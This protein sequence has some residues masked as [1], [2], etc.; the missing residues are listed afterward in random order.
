MNLEALKHLNPEQV[1]VDICLV[2][3][4]K[5]VLGPESEVDEIWSYVGKKDNPR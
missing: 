3:L 2:Q 1:K 5:E 4:P